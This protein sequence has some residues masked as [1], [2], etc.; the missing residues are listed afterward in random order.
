MTLK[1]GSTPSPCSGDLQ[2]EDTTMRHYPWNRIVSDMLLLSLVLFCTVL[3]G[4][5]RNS[6]QQGL[7]LQPSSRLSL[8]GSWQIHPGDAASNSLYHPQVD[9]SDWQSIS[10]PSNWYLQGIDQAGGNYWYRKQFQIASNMRGKMIQLVFAGVDYTADVW[11]NGHY[12]GFHEGYFSPFSF[13]VSA[14]LDFEGVNHLAVFV[15]SP[16]EEPGRVWSLHKEQIKG[17]L[18]HHDTRPGGAW[19]VRGQEKNSGGIWA[20]VFLE[21]SDQVYVAAMTITPKINDSQ[22]EAEAEVHMIVD[23]SDTGSPQDCKGVTLDLGMVPSNFNSTAEPI[24]HTLQQLDLSP[25][26]NHL[27]FSVQVQS[28]QLWWPWELGQP[29]L[30]RLTA[31]F[32]HGNSVFTQASEVFGFRSIELDR[33]TMIWKINGKR[34]FL[35]GTNYIGSIYLSEMDRD[36]FGY[37]LQL[38]KDAYINAI[39]VHAHVTG[40]DFYDMADESGM[41]VWQD[42]PL[43]WGYSDNEQF[44]VE[45]RRQA[46][47]MVSG[48][49]NHPSIFVWCGHNEPPWDADW[50]KWK[51]PDYSPDQNTKLDN[52]LFARLSELDST[53]TIQKESSTAE[54]PWFGWYSGSWL[55]YGKPATLPLITEFGAQ[56]LPAKST[57]ETIF[58]TENL[59]PKNDTQ[60]EVWKYHNFQ[61]HETFNLAGVKQGESLDEFIRNTQSYQARLNQ[62]AAESYRR[63]RFQPV[64]GI[65]QFMFVEHW[66][67]INWGIVD[68]LRQPKPGYTALQTAYQL[69]LPSIEYDR[70][71]WKHNETVQ[72]KLWLVNDYKQSFSGLQ[73][74]MSLRRPDHSSVD[75]KT[76]STPVDADSIRYLGDH[77]WSGLPDGQYI[78][79]LLLQD[80]EG[81][82]LATN[83]YEFIVS[84]EK[85]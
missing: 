32:L 43:Q 18:N 50:M 16:M 45:T 7:A 59:W 72:V 11:L 25:G 62:Y 79:E 81:K 42:F 10:V 34:L 27:Q 60:W 48:L 1:T 85:I 17:I 40:P 14:L 78:L 26:R 49:Y 58:A 5:A 21:I 71:V 33:P 46:A 56:A 22:D 61:P 37:D 12:L 41:L 69:L 80:R 38:M 70:I 13:D 39:R 47:E 76:I 57:L 36:K 64:S 82:K 51:Y 54:H 84:A 67:S 44:I 4:C 83:S 6:P 55:D 9:D 77:S 29:N 30:Y 28:P 63:Q 66:P 31:T 19:S 65:F 20:P 74:H 75:V 15:K 53:R 68:Y 2:R 35:R 23:C 52:D 24:P 73:L 8:N 3:S